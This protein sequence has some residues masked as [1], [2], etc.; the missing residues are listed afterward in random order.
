MEKQNL[1]FG[2]NILKSIVATCLAKI[3]FVL[4]K[5]KVWSKIAKV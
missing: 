1:N 5:L 3:T 2:K 4:K